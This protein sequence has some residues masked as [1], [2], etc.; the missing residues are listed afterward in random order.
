MSIEVPT[1]DDP[2]HQRLL[3]WELTPPAA[4]VPSSKNA[5]AAELG[6]SDRTLRTWGEKPE[7]QAA[8]RLAFQAVAGSLERTKAILDQLYADALDPKNEKRVMAAKL[9][10]EI[11]KAISPPEPETQTSRRAQELSD[12]DLRSFLSE[13]AADELSSRFARSASSPGS[14]QSLVQ[15]QTAVV[16]GEATL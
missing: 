11:A 10:W 5:L 14:Q 1:L 3:E 16:D 2:R 12:A 4:R 9:H 6:V 8:W 13:A 15:H 7:F